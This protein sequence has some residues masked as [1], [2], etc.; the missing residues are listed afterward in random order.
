VVGYK[1]RQLLSGTAYS[2]IGAAISN[3]LVV[4][5]HYREAKIKQNRIIIRSRK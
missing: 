3:E 1:K 4:I 5:L 2:F